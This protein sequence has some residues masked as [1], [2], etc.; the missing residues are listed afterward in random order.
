MM[1]KDAIEI[2]IPHL[3]KDYQN[4]GLGATLL[5]KANRYAKTNKTLF[6]V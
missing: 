3:L 2:Q 4:K 1:K 5:A 6:Y